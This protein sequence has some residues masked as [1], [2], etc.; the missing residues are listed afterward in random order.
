MTGSV[1]PPN[2]V[3]ARRVKVG[4]SLSLTDEIPEIFFSVAVT[5]PSLTSA[6]GDSYVCVSLRAYLCVYLWLCE[7]VRVCVFVCARLCDCS[8]VCVCV[9]VCVCLEVCVFC[10]WCFCFLWAC[11]LS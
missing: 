8:Y 10:V 5:G 1:P 7:R 3:S 4:F 6:I 9:C 2:V 11:T